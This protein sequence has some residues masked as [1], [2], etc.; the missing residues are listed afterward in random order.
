MMTQETYRTT[1]PSS[2]SRRRRRRRRSS[3][4]NKVPLLF[5]AQHHRK[6]SSLESIPEDLSKDFAVSEGLSSSL[7]SISNSDDDNEDTIDYLNMVNHERARL[8][9]APLV[10]SP[11]LDRL[12]ELHCHHMAESRNVYHS[13]H[14]IDELVAQLQSPHAAENVQR[15]DS[16]AGMHRETLAQPNSVN[17]CNLVSTVFTEFGSAACRG[18][19]GKVYHCQLFRN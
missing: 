14:S 12:A 16:I 5:T 13:V 4:N 15:G 10:S 11:E 17:Y 2:T 7:S 18:R 3:R 6:Q 9:L 8:H 19:D 1:S